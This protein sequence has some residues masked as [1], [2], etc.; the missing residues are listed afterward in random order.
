MPDEQEN[1]PA[2][3]AFDDTPLSAGSVR[4]PSETSNLTSSITF[5][6]ASASSARD[7]VGQVEAFSASLA[8]AKM[9]GEPLRL[10]GTVMEL[11]EQLG[12]V[13]DDLGGE[14]RRHT[15][16][17]E[18]YQSVGPA[19]GDKAFNTSTGPGCPAGPT[20]TPTPGPRD[21]SELQRSL[22]S[23]QLR[24]PNRRRPG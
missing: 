22:A 21:P 12:A 23:G 9:S 3:S 18:A 17:A 19:A 1:C 13:F 20:W 10:A 5:C 15:V 2:M 7:L 6:E 11:A 14:L 24:P 4:P 16:V 8:A